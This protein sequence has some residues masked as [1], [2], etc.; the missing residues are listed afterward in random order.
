ETYVYATDPAQ[1]KEDLGKALERVASEIGSA[2]A[3]ATNSTRLGTDTTV[4]QALFNSIDWSGEIK[5]IPL[6]ANGTTS[7]TLVWKTGN[8]KFRAHDLRN[9]VTY[10]GTT[11]VNFRWSEISDAQKALLRD[12]DSEALGQARLNWLRGQSIAGMRERTT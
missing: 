12:G 10:N 1:L 6:N 8:D 4:Y 11:G 3:V 7:D 2:S 5:A 9:I